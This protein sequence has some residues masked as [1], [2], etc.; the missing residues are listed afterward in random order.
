MSKLESLKFE[1]AREKLWIHSVSW[2]WAMRH[3]IGEIEFE[4]PKNTFSLKDLVSETTLIAEENL[5]SSTKRSNVSNEMASPKWNSQA[6]KE[7][8]NSRPKKKPRRGG[9]PNERFDGI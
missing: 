7:I 1:S 3:K 8:E 2:T 5:R 6:T 4:D 9:A